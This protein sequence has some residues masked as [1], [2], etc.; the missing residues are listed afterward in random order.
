MWYEAFDEELKQN[1]QALLPLTDVQIKG[2][3]NGTVTKLEVQLK[4]VNDASDSP[5]ECVFEFPLKENSA[6]TKV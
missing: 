3:L 4:Y 6:V 1:Y 5:I 2:T